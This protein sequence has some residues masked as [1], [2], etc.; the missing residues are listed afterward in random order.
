M[1]RFTV[2]SLVKDPDPNG[3]TPHFG[4]SKRLFFGNSRSLSLNKLV[5]S[6]CCFVRKGVFVVCLKLG[7]AKQKQYYSLIIINARKYL[8][9]FAV[10]ELKAGPMFK[11]G[12]RILSVCGFSAVK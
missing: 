2:S 1:G 7:V 8:H 9:S 6:G 4:H 3:K 5:L 12:F 11:V 10:S